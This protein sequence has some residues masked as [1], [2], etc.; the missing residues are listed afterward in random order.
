MKLFIYQVRKY[1]GKK[2]KSGHEPFLIFPRLQKSNANTGLHGKGFGKG[3]EQ[4]V[5]E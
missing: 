1:C 3:K 5:K 2:G 4:N